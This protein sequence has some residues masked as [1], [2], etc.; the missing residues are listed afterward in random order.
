ML[1]LLIWISLVGYVGLQQAP[2]GL[3]KGPLLEYKVIRGEG[4]GGG[5]RPAVVADGVRTP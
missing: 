4:G 3:E 2:H 5:S 1:I